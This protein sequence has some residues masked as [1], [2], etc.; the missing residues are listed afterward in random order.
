MS[1]FEAE[2]QGSEGYR[3]G[4]RTPRSPPGLISQNSTLAGGSLGLKVF[5]QFK[6]IWMYPDQRL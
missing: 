4:G 6:K 5:T 1:K 2:M 3:V